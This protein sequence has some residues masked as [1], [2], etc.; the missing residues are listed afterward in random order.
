M[1]VAFEQKNSGWEHGGPDEA[2]VGNERNELRLL[3]RWLLD[4]RRRREHSATVVVREAV[5]P[6]EMGGSLEAILASVSTVVS[7]VQLL[8]SYDTW[9]QA[10]RP[11]SEIVIRVRGAAPGDLEVA[12]RDVPGV[13]VLSDED[14]DEGEDEG[15][16]E[17]EAGGEGQ[18]GRGDADAPPEGE[19]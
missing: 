10:R 2:G 19:R 11:G 6:G 15:E 14:E 9:R 18:E 1:K 16:D 5:R 17:D 8:M 3:H 4:A 7:L 13:T 12:R